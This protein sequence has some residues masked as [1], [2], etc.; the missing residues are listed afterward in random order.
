MSI[1]ANVSVTGDHVFKIIFMSVV[2]SII[3]A[4]IWQAD[5]L[6]SR[7]GIVVEKT[8]SALVAKHRCDN[9]S[10]LDSRRFVVLH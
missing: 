4:V 10:L 8:V 6:Q 2:S 1:C 7:D 5:Q 3:I 9:V